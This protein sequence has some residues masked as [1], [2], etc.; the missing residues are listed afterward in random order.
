VRM[1][2]GCY[3]C[4]PLNNGKFLERLIRKKKNGNEKFL[5]KT[6]QISC[7][8]EKLFYFCTRFEKQAK[9]IKEEHVPRHIELTAVL[10]EILKQIIKSNRIDRFE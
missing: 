9:R 8:L 10:R 6:S 2:N 3:I 1:E 7:Q 4:T 5:K